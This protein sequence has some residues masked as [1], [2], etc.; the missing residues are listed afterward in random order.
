MNYTGGI[1]QNFGSAWTATLLG[2]LTG[3]VI[4]AIKITNASILWG[5]ILGIVVA[6]LAAL[7]SAF[8]D[9]LLP[10]S[11]NFSF[12]AGTLFNIA[13]FVFFLYVLLSN[14]IFSM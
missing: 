8:F 9:Y 12:T 10:Y 5:I 1:L 13:L 3:F 4:G 14:N 7:V 11:L 6:V 2:F